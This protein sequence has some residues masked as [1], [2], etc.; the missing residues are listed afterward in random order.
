MKP[1]SAAAVLVGL[2]ACSSDS[3][4]EAASTE[5]TKGAPISVGAI[6]PVPCLFEQPLFDGTTTQL[7]FADAITAC[8][9]GEGPSGA[10]AVFGRAGGG[11]DRYFF[12]VYQRMQSAAPLCQTGD[13]TTCVVPGFN[14]TPA[15]LVNCDTSC[16]D[17]RRTAERWYHLRSSPSRNCDAGNLT[18]NGQDAV[19]PLT[20]VRETVYEVFPPEPL[21]V[22]T[23]SEQR[24]RLADSELRSAGINLCIALQLRRASPGASS[25]E[26][27]LLSEAE[28]RELLEVIR[29]R[30]QIAMLDYALLGTVL[31]STPDQAA[32]DFLTIVSDAT[33]A[34]DLETAKRQTIVDLFQYF[35]GIPEPSADL[36]DRL[37][38]M[39]R[40]FA[41]AIQLHAEVTRELGDL[42]ARSRSARAI[43]DARPTTRSEEE[44]GS[45]SWHQRLLVATF[46]GDPLAVAGAAS[47]D[48]PWPNRLGDEFPGNP[49]SL[50]RLT[51]L[52]GP[53]SP[54]FNWPTEDRIPFHT[55]G[56]SDPRARDMLDLAKAADRL[57]LAFQVVG[58]CAAYDIEAS[59]DQLY[60]EV[61]AVLRVR[62]CVDFDGDPDTCPQ[63]PGDVLPAPGEYGDPNTPDFVLETA[64]ALT[65]EDARAVVEHLAEAIRLDC[66]PGTL[67]SDNR[68]GPRAFVGSLTTVGSTIHVDP[69]FRTEERTLADIGP[70]FT[71]YSQLKFPTPRDPLSPA[72]GSLEPLARANRQGFHAATILTPCISGRDLEPCESD[73]AEKK[74]LLG[75]FS[76]L[77][78]TR[79]MA[80][81]SAAVI[82]AN[83]SN[84]PL[85]EKAAAYL[86]NVP[87][88]LE[89]LNSLNGFDAVALSPL[90][91]PDPAGAGELVVSSFFGFPF[92]NLVVGFEA[93]D[94]FW[95]LPVDGQGVPI[96]GYIHLIV[97]IQDAIAADLLLDPE[98]SFFGR[99][100]INA[101]VA[102]AALAGRLAR[103]GGFPVG[104]VGL[105]GFFNG[106]LAFPA[107]PAQPTSTPWTIFVVRLQDDNA[108]LL[109][110]DGEAAE[111][112]LVAA[113]SLLELFD[114]TDAIYLSNS[115]SL[116]EWLEQQIDPLDAN[117]TRH[118]YDGFGFRTDWVP[119]F[120]AEV[121]GGQAGQSSV[122]FYLDLAEQAADE[123]ARAVED[124]LE[125]LQ[126][127]ATDEAVAR[128]AVTRAQQGI[129]EARSSLCGANNDTCD[130]EFVTTTPQREWYPGAPPSPALGCNAAVNQ[131]LTGPQIDDINGDGDIDEK[132]LKIEAV[133][134]SFALD[135]IA[136][137]VTERYLQTELRI[138][139]PVF[140]R[141][142]EPTTPQF[143][144]F[145]G[146]E[147]QSAFIEQWTA[148]RAPG[149]ALVTLASATRTVQQQL[150]VAVEALELARRQKKRACRPGRWFKAFAEGL[151]FSPTGGGLNG[152]VSG[153]S[154][155]FGVSWSP[156]ALLNEGG[157]CG[158]A[159]QQLEVANQ[160][161]I[162][163]FTDAFAALASATSGFVDASGRLQ[164]STATVDLLLN[165]ATLAHQR[166]VLEEELA[167]VTNLTSFG[168]FRRYT[169]QDLF[170]ARAAVESSRR[171]A[172]AAR[173]ALESRWV[174]DLSE[175]VQ[176]EPFVQSPALWADEVYDYDL[177]LPSAVG[178]EIASTDPDAIQANKIRDY[179][180]N[181]RG[182]L[183]GFPVK[184]PTAVSRGEIDVVTLPGLAPGTE[185][186]VT[187]PPDDP[188]D[189]PTIADVFAERGQWVVRCPGS[190]EFEPIPFDTLAS[191]ACGFDALGGAIQPERVKLSF[192]LDPWG[193]IND[194]VANEPFSRR[195]NGRWGL[196][197]V[198]FVGTGVKD[199]SKAEDRLACFNEG[200]IRYDLSHVGPAWITDF[201]E[202]WRQAGVPVGRI[203]GAK[204]L[205]AELWLDPLR[206][207]WQTPFISSV[208]RTEFELRPLGGGY[209]LEVDVTPEIEVDRIERVQLL[210]GTGFWV[211]QD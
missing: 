136:G 9:A 103:G 186:P 110:D 97:G 112:R 111:Y 194:T 70:T 26:T 62:D 182:F 101:I 197:A 159:K 83:Q 88:S 157:K 92:W 124:A 129:R 5:A 34:T 93:D 135:C 205:A 196:L 160:T 193:R 51:G 180:A 134:V 35:H 89:V 2:A 138:A 178:L 163:S 24:T 149:D 71:R 55:E 22:G 69:Q 147:L 66:E 95:R 63:S 77:T 201:D 144:E 82:G 57:D 185:I 171:F 104:D 116:G 170:R 59:A 114:P 27:L 12:D 56:L 8:T 176:P 118:K 23:P 102:E 28:Q 165:Q 115:G 173:R 48:G 61:E 191:E 42:I 96:P 121:I 31:V 49:L 20:P 32:A 187:I 127:E 10:D 50:L 137:A 99:G 108:N 78:A 7:L 86:S 91:T 14:D 52:R 155:G 75:A 113:N 189:P 43:T 204:G 198:N 164:Q 148:V 33:A 188:A 167:D 107:P 145:Q 47:G 60:R 17:P 150:V 68:L 36:A 39:G 142:L 192:Q 53:Q 199:C 74:R 41:T 1:W 3:G 153:G 98:R 162:Q 123:S 208:A 4:H 131:L 87:S 79:S 207:G 181:L 132:D 166:F 133:E 18:L 175:L 156:Q 30:A 25:G 174:V 151:S 109:P 76:A 106:L 6:S 119:P 58:G 117:P 143:S 183:A 206:D 146:G 128:A 21:G 168:L 210:V 11:V 73:I 81:S 130:V 64:H 172:L 200:F 80:A 139:Q 209:E 44:W 46:G 90:T 203:E 38:R 40:D 13:P 105:P 152:L 154:G 126:Q 211:K 161:V 19:I 67:A 94:D 16:T 122:E 179:I 125:N 141:I 84:L 54:A 65:P 120:T 29:E 45:R 158:D 140:E 202:I 195:F 184:R 190:D 169:S 85:F 72:P 177:S 15:P 100:N 37:P